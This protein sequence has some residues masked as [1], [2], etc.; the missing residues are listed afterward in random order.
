MSD[1]E[2]DPSSNSN[3]SSLVVPDIKVIALVQ[4]IY[5]LPCEIDAK[6]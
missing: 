6:V 2:E 1:M 4:L 5:L 3:S